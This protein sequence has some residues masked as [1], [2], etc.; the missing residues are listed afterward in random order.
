VSTDRRAGVAAALLLARWWSQ[1]TSGELDSWRELWVHAE[2]TARELALQPEQVDELRAAAEAASEQALLDDYERLLVGPGRVRCAPYESLWRS[3]L[4]ANEQ[5]SLMGAAADAVTGVYRDLGLE[6]RGDAHELPDHLLVE[7]EA[8][9]YALEHEAGDAIAELLNEHL[10]RWVEPFCA[11]VGAEAEEPFYRA[12][13][14]ITP[15]WTAA[16]AR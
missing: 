9:A 13:A 14:G 1:P 5:G 4:P 2:D 8:L 12:L 7:Y 11:A 16:L 15:E 10:G 6:V 3:D